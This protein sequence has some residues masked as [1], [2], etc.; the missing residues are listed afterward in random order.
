MGT[1]FVARELAPAGVRS[2]PKSRLQLR[3]RAGASS[4]ATASPLPQGLCC[5]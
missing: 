1:A 3:C 2:A 5:S 4:L